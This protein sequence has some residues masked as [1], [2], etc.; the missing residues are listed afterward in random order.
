MGLLEIHPV[1][2]SQNAHREA[3]VE[4]VHAYASDPMAGSQGLT[5]EARQRL[6]EGLAA[7]PTAY[8]FLAIRDNKPLGAAVCVLGFSTFAGRPLM[9][10]HDMIVL[11]EYRGQGI[12]KRL[13]EAVDAK[14]QELGCCKVTLEV[15]EDN[16]KAYGL[17]R[18]HGFRDM[19]FGGEESR[20]LFLEKS[21]T[22]KIHA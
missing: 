2:W 11:A 6:A 16:P 14:S 5:Q 7:F 20:V 12:G 19:D 1:D 22:A 13:L 10:V 15:R 17:Y 21:L 4:M 8:A 3:L 18:R 9:N